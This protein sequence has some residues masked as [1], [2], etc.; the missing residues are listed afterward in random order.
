M[1]DKVTLSNLVN[2]QNETSAVT[3]INNNNA[4]ITTAMNNTLSRDGTTPNTMNSTLDMNSNRVVN[5]PAPIGNS[6]PMRLAD[7]KTFIGGGTIQGVP[8]GGTTG[9]ALVKNSNTNFDVK[10]GNTI[11][12][13]GLALPSDFTISGSPVTTAGT[14]T[15]A[16][17]TTPTGTGAV[18]RTTAPSISNASIT[19][20]TLDTAN[21]NTLKLLGNTITAAG[22]GSST[23]T[24]PQTTIC[25]VDS[26]QTLTNKTLTAPI[27]S[28][29]SNTGTLTLPTST[30][31]LVG[32][33]TTD[34]FSNKIINN[35]NSNTIQLSG[36]TL[37]VGQY[38]GETSTGSAAAGFV[39]EYIIS[40]VVSGSAI[41][42][43]ASTA[44]NVT[45]L[46]LTAGDWDVYGFC[47]FIPAATTSMT[48]YALSTSTTTGALDATTPF[49][50][51]KF[52]QAANVPAGLDSELF[53]GPVRFSV[54]GSTPV[55][56]VARAIFTVS[57]MTAYGSIRARRVR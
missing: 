14:L 56:L 42:L 13:V 47:G 45:S 25:G 17:V 30:D 50:L 27:I 41:G 57:T 35:S 4:A 51:T 31:T 37:L 3:T 23:I 20:T 9:Q 15:G 33:A 8:A 43:T 18:V 24:L 54:S 29:I 28:T 53:C 11:T 49:A 44:A 32:K 52:S 48:Q 7:L 39:G 26:T 22:S 6:E 10:Y 2:L 1:T 55:F 38:P 16:W 34:T 46:T 5:L 36:N 40:T 21:G 19:G 12:S